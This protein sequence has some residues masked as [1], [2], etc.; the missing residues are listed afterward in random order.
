L[1][2]WAFMYDILIKNG[3]IIDGSGEAM[4]RA[5]IGIKEEKIV[6]IGNLQ[7]EKAET[8]I[9]A[10]GRF[11]CPGFVDVNNHSDTYWQIFSDPDLESLVYQGITTIIGGNCGASLAP[12]T[13]RDSIQSIQ[14]WVNL[15]K[16]SFSWM[17][18]EEFF[19]FLEKKKLSVNFGT[20]VGHSTLRR[21]I[22]H[23][24]SREMAEKEMQML[25]NVLTDSLQ[26]GALGI[27]AGLVYVHA[28]SATQEEL[29]RLAKVIKKQQ[30]IFVAHLRD[31]KENFLQSIEEILQIAE[32]TGVK[33]HISHLKVMGEKNW[34]LMDK[35]L[36]MLKTGQEKG[37]EITFDVYP[38]TSTG[39]VLYTLLPSWAAVGGRKMML[40]R[41][42]DPM[43][44]QKIIADM[45]KTNFDYSKIKIAISPILKSL[46]RRDI[47]EIA[48]AQEKS[49]EEALLDI[50]LASE[51]Q[52][53]ISMDVLNE[54]NIE[55]IIQQPSA[56]ISSNGAGY[57]LA[58]AKTGEVIHPRSF[59]TFPRI[60][61]KYVLQ[62]Q[63]I[64]WEEAIKKMTSLPA[65]LFAL[66]KRGQIK[67]KY[68]ADLIIINRDQIQDLATVEN[69]Y[70]YSRGI[71]TVLVN[72][73]IVLQE[74]KYLGVKN[75]MILKKD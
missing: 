35:A 49:I 6:K 26:K 64:S 31:E 41:L 30:G 42:K 14:K 46:A 68:F 72:G 37:L 1:F 38:Y 61:H 15:G 63:I 19:A 2:F 7:N 57:N 13:G 45:H 28:A 71:D 8:E 17:K 43:M 3:I 67:E 16:I 60:L 25:E 18:M 22:M 66:A 74:G 75:G 32:M 23:D 54:E 5:D 34:G 11:V 4:L 27:S 52:A 33:M 56:I 39:T 51:C 59:G 70:Q 29:V 44:R 47:R 24:E 40:Q 12:L 36:D 73:K 9:D 62:R 69:P 21:G 20:L 55:K 65:E 53:V 58:H 48:A 10:A 50:L